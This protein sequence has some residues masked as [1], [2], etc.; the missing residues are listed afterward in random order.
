MI[1][2]FRKEILKLWE[3]TTISHDIVWI[4]QH[5]GVSVHD[6]LIA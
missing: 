5:V 3:L 1:I 4:Y 6:I 2:I